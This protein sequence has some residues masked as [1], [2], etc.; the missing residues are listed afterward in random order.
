MKKLTKVLVACMLFAMMAVGFTACGSVEK[1]VLGDWTAS[2]INGQSI[3]DFAAANNLTTDKVAMNMHVES[4][5]VVLS[6]VTGSSEYTPDFKSNGFELM[7]NGS[8]AM[9][10]T[11]D[12]DATT[13]SFE[14][15]ASD[16]QQSIKYVLKK[17]TFDFSA[18]PAEG[19][20]DAAEE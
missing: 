3:E 19:G 9:S 13:L 5:K 10:V 16:T 6:G 11:Y 12:K 7:L 1:D 15:V 18:A 2:T 8:I 4:G 17:G 20:E 14:I